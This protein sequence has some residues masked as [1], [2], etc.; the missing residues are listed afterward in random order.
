MKKAIEGTSLIERKR[1]RE[2]EGGGR[3]R[4]GGRGDGQR[5][6]STNQT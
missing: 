5:I 6:C 2:R 4:V 3:K 1:E